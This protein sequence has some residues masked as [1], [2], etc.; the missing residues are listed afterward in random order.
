M[1]MTTMDRHHVT[2]G[3][4]VNVKSLSLLPRHGKWAELGAQAEKVGGPLYTL[5]V[6]N[7]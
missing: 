4:L 1:N 6:L 3:C 5:Q 7:E 2:C